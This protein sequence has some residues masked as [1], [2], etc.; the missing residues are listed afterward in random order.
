MSHDRGVLNVGH[1]VN[2]LDTV[3]NTVGIIRI[4]NQISPVRMSE[5]L[6]CVRDF[7][8]IRKKKTNSS[9]TSKQTANPIGIVE[10]P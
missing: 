6:I 8:I 10:F 3:P 1:M 7:G 5:C 4:H 9:D 2:I